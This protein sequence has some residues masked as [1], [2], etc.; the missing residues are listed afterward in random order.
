M[1]YFKLT[2]AVAALIAT[3][4]LASV[5]SA[6]H[7]GG[8][9]HGGRS[10]AFGGRSAGF[11]GGLHTRSYHPRQSSFNYGTQRV[12]A[13]RRGNY[14]RHGNHVH[15]ISPPIQTFRTPGCSYGSRYGGGYGYS[16]RSRSGVHIGSGGLGIRTPGFNLRIGR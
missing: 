4:L 11:S 7:L 6:D 15:R 3:P 13:T 10:S 14:I 9:F 1:N 8:S 2:A 12:P 5:A 16:P